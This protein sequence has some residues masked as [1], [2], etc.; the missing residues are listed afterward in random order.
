MS[1]T[2]QIVMVSAL[3]NGAITWGVMTTKLAWMRRDID[4]LEDR[5]KACESRHFQRR[6]SDL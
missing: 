2:L 3:V 5:V 1:E 6:S 4:R